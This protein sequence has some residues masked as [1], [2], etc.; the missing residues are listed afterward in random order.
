VNLED[1]NVSLHDFLEEERLLL[2]DFWGAWC[3]GC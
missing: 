1:D 2:I 3:M